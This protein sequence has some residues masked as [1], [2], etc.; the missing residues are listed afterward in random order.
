MRFFIISSFLILRPLKPG[1]GFMETDPPLSF[2]EYDD[3]LP[4]GIRRSAFQPVNP[5]NKRTRR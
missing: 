4:A 5:H 1:H 2:N 3:A